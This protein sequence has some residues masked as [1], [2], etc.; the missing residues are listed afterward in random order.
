METEKKKEVC[1]QVGVRMPKKEGQII[2]KAGLEE[3][4]FTQNKLKDIKEIIAQWGS[5]QDL[6]NMSRVQETF[7]KVVHGYKVNWRLYL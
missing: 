2:A 1:K 7:D 6:N 3:L 5:T 4:I